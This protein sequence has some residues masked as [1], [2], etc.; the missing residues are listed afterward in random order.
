ML[1]YFALSP[2]SESISCCEPFD[3]EVGTF[4]PNLTSEGHLDGDYDDDDAFYDDYDDRAYL[5]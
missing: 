3:K 5:T 2:Y 4:S 1:L